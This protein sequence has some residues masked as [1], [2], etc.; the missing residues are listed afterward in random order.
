MFVINPLPPQIERARLEHLVKAEPATIGHFVQT[1]FMDPGLRCLMQDIRI[2]GTA[3]TIRYPGVDGTIVHYALGQIRPG[4]VLV[5][6]RC[7]DMTHAS[8]GGAVAY[9]AARA[10]CSGIIVDGLVTDIAELRR[11]GVPVWARGLSTTTNKRL[12][13]AG[14]FC[15]PISC[16]G[17]AVRPGAAILADENG[18]LVLEPEHIEAWANRAIAMQDEEKKM[19]RRLDA[20]EKLPEINGVNQLIRDILDKQRTG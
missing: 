18:V 9:A 13:S 2:A 11:Y 7:G 8:A 3:V 14:E 10:G 16:G 1:G 15:V 6:D 19:L 5:M 17:V 12:L 4:D 20:G